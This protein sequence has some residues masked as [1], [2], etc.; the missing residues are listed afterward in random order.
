M[1]KDTDFK[2]CKGNGSMHCI[3]ESKD[4]LEHMGLNL[5]FAVYK[6]E[7]DYSDKIIKCEKY[8]KRYT[9]NGTVAHRLVIPLNEH[10]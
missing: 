6:Y 9:Y 1:I 8:E 7:E 2:D 10:R 4:E 3:Q 5:T